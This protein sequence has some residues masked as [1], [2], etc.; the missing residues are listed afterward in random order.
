MLPADTPVEGQKTSV[1]LERSHT[2]PRRATLHHVKSSQYCI[3]LRKLHTGWR[4]NRKSGS[5][6]RVN[7]RLNDVR[8]VFEKRTSLGD[9]A[10]E[11]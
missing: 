10:D 1:S 4:V 3:I 7:G 5:A 2:P 9:D 11:N 8:C 6:L